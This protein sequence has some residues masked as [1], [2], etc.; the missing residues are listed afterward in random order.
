MTLRDTIE[1]L[2]LERPITEERIVAEMAKASRLAEPGDVNT[3]LSVAKLHDPLDQLIACPAMSLLPAWGTEG[4]QYLYEFA[5]DGPHSSDAL[6][7]LAIVSLGRV[8]TSADLVFLRKYW[9]ELEKYKLDLGIV[10]ESTR[11]VREAILDH[12]T[13]PYMKTRL[14]NVISQQ[15]MFPGNNSTQGQHFQAERLHF[16]MDTLI[17]SHLILNK[18]VLEQFEALL[19][20]G[21]EREERLQRF[22]VEHPVLLD[23]FVTEL[24]SKHELGDDFITDFVVRRTNNEYVVVEIENSTDQLFKQNSAFTQDLMT[25][26]GQVRDFQAWIS[27]NI[28]YAQTKLPGIRH[29][30]GLVVI[31]RRKTLLPEM[32]KRL[33]EEN[34]SRRGHIK[35]VTYDDLLSQGWSVYRNAIERPVIL[36]SRDQKSI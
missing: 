24:R 31:G 29:P 20:Q 34:F 18:E 12:L 16:L 27:D 14:L 15:A 10:P 2:L 21:P 22:L 1:R 17:D 32:E 11:R 28:A 26:V 6:S 33:S 3:I 25:A 7:I 8:P 5:I 19:E 36:R 30:D 13:D 9:D 4:I 23:P 35:I